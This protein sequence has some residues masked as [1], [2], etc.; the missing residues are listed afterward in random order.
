MIPSYTDWLAYQERYK[1]LLREAARER[2]IRS[3]GLRRPR[4]W[5]PH[6]RV[7]GWIGDQMV[8]LGWMLQHYGTTPP[9]CCPQVSGSSGAGL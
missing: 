8:R 5:R 7:I 4:G 2:M 3:T 1:D 6:R 9:P